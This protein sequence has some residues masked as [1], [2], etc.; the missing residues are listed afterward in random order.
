ME[1]NESRRTAM[2]PNL[3]DEQF[4]KSQSCLAYIFEL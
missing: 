1:L 2:N 3:I 4:I